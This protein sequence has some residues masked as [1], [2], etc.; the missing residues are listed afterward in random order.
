M[1]VSHH[2]RH[3]RG[4]ASPVAPARCVVRG[5]PPTSTW[6]RLV[7]PTAI[8]AALLAALVLLHR[9]PGLLVTLGPKVTGHG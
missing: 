1:K 4:P 8:E 9:L 5:L 6:L 7:T 3:R 2:V